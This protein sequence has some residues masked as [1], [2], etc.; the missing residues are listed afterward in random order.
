M[1]VVRIGLLAALCLIAAPGCLYVGA[2]QGFDPDGEG[3]E[4]GWHLIRVPVVRQRV[5]DECGAVCAEMVA[6]DS[7]GEEAGRRAREGVAVTPGR[8][9]RADE[10]VTALRGAGLEVFLQVGTIEQLERH[11]N[12]GRPLI[13]GLVQPYRGG[14][15]RTHYVVVAGANPE[16]GI[17]AVIDPARGWRRYPYGG[18]Q[19]EWDGS[20]CVLIVAAAATG[21]TEGG[22]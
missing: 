21:D 6:R 1:R 17:L 19:A 22:D 9:S 18:F 13:A 16:R 10:L 12:R 3:K 4:Q 2:G 11:L 20:G 8:G 7:L 5:A 14:V 15:R